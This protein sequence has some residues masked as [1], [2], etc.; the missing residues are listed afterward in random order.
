MFKAIT[1]AAFFVSLI[2]G[3]SAGAKKNATP[4]PV[5][6][7]EVIEFTGKNDQKLIDF[8]KTEDFAGLLT[9]VNEKGDRRIVDLYSFKNIDAV[10]MNEALCKSILAKMF[11]PLD[12]I[13][14]KL[15][16]TQI[17]A[18][19]TG[20]TC[21]AQL[22]DEDKE[23]KIPERRVIVGFLNAKPTALVMR[24]SKKSGAEDSES[25]RKFWDTLR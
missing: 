9:R 12:K 1:V 21:E 19:H 24:F 2:L 10:P 20:K 16:K 22:D 17:Y 25:I 11:G 4:S 13:S 14:L 5:I 15:K 18:S 8:A 23:A 7:S 6:S 3:H